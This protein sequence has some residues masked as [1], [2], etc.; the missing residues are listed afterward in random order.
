V[1][2]KA[3]RWVGVDGEG[4]G[5]KPH[6]YVLLACSDGDY[7]ENR[8]GLSTVQCLDF[9]LDLGSRDARVCGYYLSYDWTMILWDIVLQDRQLVH[10]LLRPE[11]RARSKG[12][13]E[14]VKFE[15]YELHWLAGAMWIRDERRKV[16][17]WDLGKFFQ[18]PFVDALKAWKIRPDVQ[19]EIAEMKKRRSRFAWREI[20]RIRKYCM[21]ECEALAELATEI[22][23]AHIAA[24]LKLRSWFG[25]GSTAGVLLH[26]HS[27]HERR[28]SLPP[29]LLEPVARA[30]FGGRAE[31]STNGYVRGPISAYDISSA[32]PYHASR[33]PCLEHGRWERVTR[34]RDL[35]GRDVVHALVHGHI[36]HAPGAWA[37][38]PIRL[39]NGT[40]V[41]PRTGASGWWWR[42]EW[43]AAR[44]GW[45][46]LKFDRGYVLRREC[47]C[48]PFEFL[49]KL[50]ERRLVVG[51]DTGEG[52]ILKLGPNSVYG[53]L[54]Q[55]IGKAQYASRAWA[56]MI[57]SGTRAQILR[58]ML[59]H[60]KLENVLMIAT[61]GLF[62]TEQ[63]DVDA[64]IRLGGWERKEYE[65]I[66]LV[67][68]GIY[69]L[70]GGEI[71]G[72]P[73]Q[74]AIR[75]ARG[76]AHALITMR[77]VD[78]RIV[79]LRASELG[80][81]KI[82]ARGMG[83]DNLDNAKVQLALALARGDDHVELA[84]RVTFGGAKVCVYA[85]GNNPEHGGLRRSEHYGQ[86]HEIPTRVSLSPAPK[87]ERD[88]ST[89]TLDDVESAPY[90]THATRMQGE[91][92]EFLELV[93]DLM[94]Y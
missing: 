78:G 81:T 16:T 55:T 51:K 41:F 72:F 94:N 56:G 76:E 9:L 90:G 21:H 2:T 53:K 4:V 10:A 83:R 75:N 58:L 69:W 77:Q 54:A 89:P 36:H 26:R 28:G 91:L 27:I 79:L 30:F 5:R 12:G 60:N 45:K 22:E 15:G 49:S 67:R 66:T 65:S 93:R 61:D 34:E 13:F 40:I 39:A 85:V 84:P 25:P 33:L 38:L 31:I 88:W 52:K 47:F 17:I 19:D 59:Q 48:K 20:S 92:F 32:Y 57:T 50:F 86:W 23:A 64:E 29:I 6:R 43:L 8:R 80:G 68:P 35:R 7:V 37:P 46:G 87:R 44:E 74:R 1:R 70:G 82:R 42:D 11:L 24:D 18:G 73:E 14:R 3:R 71:L 62:S 63:H